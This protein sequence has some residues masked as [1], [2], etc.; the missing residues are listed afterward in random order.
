MVKKARSSRKAVFH[1]LQ[2]SILKF[3]YILR[4]SHL[5]DAGE[6]AGHVSPSKCPVPVSHSILYLPSDGHY[7]MMQG[8][9]VTWLRRR[10]AGRRGRF[11]SMHH[12]SLNV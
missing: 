9:N 1:G 7:R 10:F 4:L 8:L 11:V 3:S 5:L 12:A 6:A 2:V